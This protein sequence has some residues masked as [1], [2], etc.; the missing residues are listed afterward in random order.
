M[1]K[2]NVL[3]FIIALFASA[4]GEKQ[5]VTQAQLDQAAIEEYIA[6]NQLVTQKTDSGLHYIITA[7][8]SAAKPSP[9]ASITVT[10]VGKLL[11]GTTFD[12]GSYFTGPLNNMIEGWKEGIP[13]IG[14]A[15]KI[16]LIIPSGLGYGNRATGKIPGN[17]VLVFDVTLHSFTNPQ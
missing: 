10:Y 17:S 5:V 9:T 15:G 3:L 6:A 7:E 11:N 12:S 1:R 14:A 4:C 16:K 13:L 8:G 2:L